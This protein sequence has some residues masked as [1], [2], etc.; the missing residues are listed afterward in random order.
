MASG[1]TFRGKALIESK[2]LEAADLNGKKI[3]RK[4]VSIR[5]GVKL[6]NSQGVDVR[7][8]FRLEGEEKEW[9]LNT[10]NLKACAKLY[11]HRAED[12][13]GKWIVLY[14]TMVDAFG[15][16]KL[17]IRVDV[18]ATRKYTANKTG[19]AA[20]QTTTQEPTQDEVDEQALADAALAA[21][22]A[23]MD[24]PGSNE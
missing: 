15:E 12:F 18:D 22:Q 21:E 23:A 20:P 5:T 16:E 3:A 14:S 8:A 4:I 9:I 13:V 10:T 6:K 17:A 2:F 7:P 19:N 11:G 1:V 24:E